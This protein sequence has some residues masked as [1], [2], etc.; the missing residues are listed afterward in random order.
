MRRFLIAVGIA[1][2]VLPARAQ[3]SG[4]DYAYSIFTG[5]DMV[6]QANQAGAE[7]RA[8]IKANLPGWMINVDKTSGSVFDMYGKAF[9][10]AGATNE[11]RSRILMAEKLNHAGINTTE[12]TTTRNTTA[13]KAAYVDYKQNIDG[14]EVLFSKLSFRFSL[15]GKITRIKKQ[16]YG[17]PVQNPAI[18]ISQ[19]QAIDARTILKD[20][21]VTN[22]TKNTANV[23]WIWFPVPTEKGYE[24]H[25]AWHVTAAGNDKTATP[26]E[27]DGYVDA[28]TGELLY[29]MNKVKSDIDVQVFGSVYKQNTITPP[30]LEPLAHLDVEV[31]TVPQRANDT[32]LFTT[33]DPVALTNIY[34]QGAWSTVYDQGTSTPSVTETFITSGPYTLPNTG[35]MNDKLINAY[36]HVNRVHDFMKQQLPSFTDMDFSLRTNVDIGGGTCN[37]FYSGS[38]IN[39]YAEGGGCKSFA[40]IGDIIYH[41]YGHAISDNF[42][43][44]QGAG[45]IFNGGLN[46]GNSDVWGMGISKDSVLGRFTNV[47]SPGSFIR[48]YDINPKVFPKDITGEVHANGEIIA[49]SWYDVAKNLGSFETMSTLFSATYFDVPDGPEGMEGMV[50]HEVLISAILADDDDNDLTNGTPHFE[51]IVRAFAK[52]GIYL[53]ADAI[54]K[55]TEVAHQPANQPINVTATLELTNPAF[56]SNLKLVYRNRSTAWDTL[57]MTNTGNFNFS[58]QIPAQP[59]SS[60]MDYYFVVYDALNAPGNTF[61]WGFVADPSQATDVTIPYQF[62]VGTHPVITV[63]FE[64]DLDTT[65]WKFGA[66]N[67]AATSGLWVQAKPFRSAYNSQRFGRFISQTGNDHTTGQGKCLVTGNTLV[68]NSYTFRSNSDVD[69]GRTTVIT[70]AYDLT[71]FVYPIIE[72]HRWYANDRGGEARRDDLWRV[73][74]VNETSSAQ[75][76]ESTRQ[77]DTAWR[78]RVFAVYQY[79]PNAKGIQLR[80]IASDNG[81]DSNIEAAVD[82][83][84][85]Y[86]GV[87][88][89]VANLPQSKAEIYP[90][91]ADDNV[92]VSF[93]KANK[94]T[95][96]I[97]DVTGKML[98]TINM[99]GTTTNYNISTAQLTPGQY[100]ISIQTDNKTYQTKKLVVTH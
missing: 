32:G 42:Y 26:F 25:P 46:E 91:P 38:S 74:M 2:S 100:M 71:G 69:N 3:D 8:T 21:N 97:F 89:S 60:L 15:D 62:A 92:H 48:R 54:L 75:V 96:S 76:I 90:N 99:D 27:L 88:L 72:Y 82:D 83:F 16:V 45:T 94:G 37:A 64:A 50:F 73:E 65:Q 53:N 86:D 77:T 7:E 30:T 81:D 18:N 28:T 31:N 1:A 52:H 39:F 34:L 87:P 98:Q 10:V 55:H 19:Q 14:H 56:F 93:T 49:G 4:N 33:T 5:S 6:S 66:S 59:M 44:D 36:Y 67:D 61:P 70:P 12:W 35:A 9:A 85:I 68:A 23:N 51:G 78:R 58:A 11:E 29:R 22:L 84:I 79:L 13:P 95:I 63:D 17:C 43:S 80:F 47:G 20:V 41:E 57:T 40:E 24:L